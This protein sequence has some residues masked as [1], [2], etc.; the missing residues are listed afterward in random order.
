MHI[1]KALDTM[2]HGVEK[3]CKKNLVFFGEFYTYEYCNIWIST[4]FC[5]Q[6]GNKYIQEELVHPTRRLGNKQAAANP[7]RLMRDGAAVV[8]LVITVYKMLMGL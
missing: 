6:S 1:S 4:V 7:I 5:I 2:Y 3:C 8:A